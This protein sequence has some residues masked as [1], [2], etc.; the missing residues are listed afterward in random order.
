MDRDGISAHCSNVTPRRPMV[1]QTQVT[2]RNRFGHFMREGTH[3]MY[4]LTF[5]GVAT[6]HQFK[7]STPTEF[8]T[9]KRVSIHFTTNRQ[10]NK[11]KLSQRRES[12][13]RVNDGGIEWADGLLD[14]AKDTEKPIVVFPVERIQ[15]YDHS[16]SRV[17]TAQHSTMDT[18][19]ASAI[20]SKEQEEPISNIILL[21]NQEQIKSDSSSSPNII[22]SSSSSSSLSKISSEDTSFVAIDDGDDDEYYDEDSYTDEDITS[23]VVEEEDIKEKSEQKNELPSRS[24]EEMMKPSE[25]TCADLEIEKDVQSLFLNNG[26]RDL[27]SSPQR[28]KS[29][30]LRAN[31]VNSGLHDRLIS[32]I[33]TTIR[34]RLTGSSKRPKSVQR[35][36]FK[37]NQI[38]ASAEEFIK[39]LGRDRTYEGI[40]MRKYLTHAS[41]CLNFDI[42]NGLP[43]KEESIRSLPVRASWLNIPSPLSSQWRRLSNETLANVISSSVDK[44]KTIKMIL[45]KLPATSQTSLKRDENGNVWYATQDLV[46]RLSSLDLPSE[47]YF[48]RKISEFD[49]LRDAVLASLQQAE[50]SATAL[51]ETICRSESSEFFALHSINEGF[52]HEQLE[53][54]HRILIKDI[55]GND[56]DARDVVLWQKLMIEMFNSEKYL[57]S[58][59]SRLN[60]LHSRAEQKIIENDEDLQ[61]QEDFKEQIIQ[62]LTQQVLSQRQLEAD[63]GVYDDDD[64]DEDEVHA[65]IE[66]NIRCNVYV[67]PFDRISPVSLYE[68]MNLNKTDILSLSPSNTPSIGIVS[69]I[70]SRLANLDVCILPVILSA[71]SLSANSFSTASLSG[72]AARICLDSSARS[73]FLAKGCAL[74]TRSKDENDI[75]ISVIRVDGCV[76]SKYA[77]MQSTF[78][79]S[80]G[81]N[82]EILYFGDGTSHSEDGEATV[83]SPVDLMAYH[84]K[85]Y[86]AAT[87]TF[88]DYKSDSKGGQRVIYSATPLVAESSFSSF[89]E[90][91][92][93]TFQTPVSIESTSDD[94]YSENEEEEIGESSSNS[95]DDSEDVISDS[96]NKSSANNS[97]KTSTGDGIIKS[98]WNF[99]RTPAKKRHQA[100]SDSENEDEEEPRKKRSKI[101]IS[102]P[103]AVEV[104]KEKIVNDKS[105]SIWINYLPSSDERKRIDQ[106]TNKRGQF[107]E[108]TISSSNRFEV[109][110]M[111]PHKKIRKPHTVS[112]LY[113]TACLVSDAL[114]EGMGT[115]TG[116]NESITITDLNKV[117]NEGLDLNNNQAAKYLNKDSIWEGSRER[118]RDEDGIIILL[119]A[120]MSNNVKK[121]HKNEKSALLHQIYDVLKAFKGCEPSIHLST[122]K[123]QIKKG[124]TTSN[125][126]C[127]QLQQPLIEAARAMLVRFASDVLI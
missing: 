6:N 121:S 26:E 113:A 37:H 93:E 22:S 118:L 84:Q 24:I 57:G 33:P 44:E 2:A 126:S 49:F 88:E 15:N 82:Q 95:S 116:V 31:E 43:V 58:I 61:S 36:S 81:V 21:S 52:K 64:E 1:Q 63:Q 40:S 18:L 16:P 92:P 87:A 108:E 56:F 65:S 101:E 110:S 59:S 124:K 72:E 70:L 104:S 68:T 47:S 28:I 60:G 123:K 35:P 98:I 10:S 109:P 14:E 50:M 77:I 71:V 120:L 75:L 102:T 19:H 38:V 117:H 11:I 53:Q 17:S 114:L 20:V 97:S 103:A 66:E 23:I 41:L 5:N 115:I 112:Y 90:E 94:D 100:K 29:V 8:L 96:E 106:L 80:S 127:E 3:K 30:L 25:Y 86:S 62:D 76:G 119:L 107:A 122:N 74:S 79:V 34:S 48:A 12:L 9:N 91:D 78:S 54:A 32:S 55:L 83:V 46:H 85:N 7:I 51:L 69:K 45:E 67:D 105:S 73:L 89:I 27:L 13:R 4:P 42:A 111:N 99:I 125:S 39:W